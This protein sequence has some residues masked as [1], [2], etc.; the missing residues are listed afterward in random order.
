MDSIVGAFALGVIALAGG[1]LWYG[2]SR[3]TRKKRTRFAGRLPL[4]AQAFWQQYSEDSG[5]PFEVVEEILPLIAEAAEIP[6]ALLRPTDRFAP[7][8]GW[9]FDDRRAELSWRAQSEAK[10]SGKRVDVFVV[11][12][13]DDAIHVYH[14]LATATDG[15]ACR[16]QP[17]AQQEKH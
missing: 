9:E 5:I 17:G 2:Q 12:T 14:E 16:E 6:A 7:E 3:A 11:R 10:R 1:A 13:V 4:T 15:C 8:K